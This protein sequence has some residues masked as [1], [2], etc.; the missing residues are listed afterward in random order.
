MAIFD[1]MCEGF[2]LVG[3]TKSGLFRPG[4]RLASMSEGELMESAQRLRPQLLTKVMQ[5]KQD[6]FSEELQETTMREASEKGWLEG[7]FSPADM[8]KR[9]GNWLPVRRFAVVDALG[10][11]LQMGC[12]TQSH[13]VSSRALRGN[14]L[15][16]S[17]EETTL[18]RSCS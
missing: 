15:N 4:V 1:E 17:F 7:P 5:E 13:S 9:F 18:P 3:H 10:S 14:T 2:R 12:K 16:I 8:D 11:A 6:D